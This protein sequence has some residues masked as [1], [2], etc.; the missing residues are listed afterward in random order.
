MLNK[1][2][3]LFLLLLLGCENPVQKNQREVQIPGR[4]TPLLYRIQ[5]PEE[6]E[7][8]LN[9]DPLSLQDT[10]N[11]LCTI[12]IGQEKPIKINIHNFMNEITPEAQVARWKNQMANS[13][14]TLSNC[15]G[16]GFAGLKYENYSEEEGVIG[17]ALRLLPKLK[18][19]VVAEMG[20][21]ITIKATGNS[22][23]LLEN[24]DAIDE[25]YQSFELIEP[26]LLS[27]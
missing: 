13:S 4:L 16:A 24:R 2:L 19:Q 8:T 12:K 18:N 3:L 21:P 20:A 27:S 7:I 22:E 9:E 5:I 11:P 17:Y 6:W 14:F 26:I 23:W 10:M 1:T 15:A 25:L